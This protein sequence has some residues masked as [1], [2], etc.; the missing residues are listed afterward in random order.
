MPPKKRPA[1]TSATVP[2]AKRKK[3][4]TGGT[5]SIGEPDTSEILASGRPKRSSIGE[6]IYDTTATKTAN[7]N[8]AKPE[9]KRSTTKAQSTTAARGRGTPRKDATAPT[10][11]RHA[12]E[13]PGTPPSKPV[14]KPKRLASAKSHSQVETATQTVQ[15][16]PRPAQ[17]AV[18]PTPKSKGRP[19]S[20]TT[21]PTTAVGTEKSADKSKSKPKT[22]KAGEK[23]VAPKAGTDEKLD[24][25]AANESDRDMI[26]E[27]K[28]KQY[29]LMKAEPDSRVE[30]GVDVKFSIDD[31]MN[32][33][34]PEGWDG[35]DQSILGESCKLT[36]MRRCPKFCGEEQ[37]ASDEEGRPGILLSL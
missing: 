36:D 6:H 29:W 21:K 35:K 8:K 20:N 33:K 13:T 7:V 9:A 27:D 26:D 16:A 11:E 32:A 10:E 4:S 30:N 18:A 14:G 2:S 15:K 22:T 28:G 37:N 31:L 1:A 34:V 3:V 25:L 12:L 17:P 19:K 23:A 5:S 24:G